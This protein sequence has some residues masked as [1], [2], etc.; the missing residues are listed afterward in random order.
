MARLCVCQT[1]R[2]TTTKLDAVRMPGGFGMESVGEYE[3]T[4]LAA[5]GRSGFMAAMET[6]G[7]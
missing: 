2:T 1:K 6:K 7:G 5:R 3:E 4:Q